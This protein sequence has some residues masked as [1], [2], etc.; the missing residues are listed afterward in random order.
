MFQNSDNK[1]F[2]F[3][4][5]TYTKRGKESRVACVLLRIG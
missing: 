1:I 5:V 4:R 2:D 3:G